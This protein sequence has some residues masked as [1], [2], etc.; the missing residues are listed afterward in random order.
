MKFQASFTL[1]NT[2]YLILL[3]KGRESVA[4]DKNWM[5]ATS[6]QPAKYNSDRFKKFHQENTAMAFVNE[7]ISKE[8]I[9][10]YHLDELKKKYNLRIHSW[11]IDRERNIYLICNGKGREEESQMKFFFLFRKGEISEHTIWQFFDHP[12][13]TLIWEM[14]RYGAPEY[15]SRDEQQKYEQLHADLRDALR[16]YGLAGVVVPGNEGY[17]NAR[18][19]NF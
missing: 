13:K 15:K 2:S 17:N 18:F 7:Y 5:I 3:T 14:Q 10:K 4:N 19:T 8:D 11:T 12:N 16:A 6:I 1:I 9:E